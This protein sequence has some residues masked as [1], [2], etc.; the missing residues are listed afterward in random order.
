MMKRF[1][2]IVLLCAGIFSCRTRQQEVKPEL[3]QLTEAIYASGT[4]VPEQEYRVMAASDG[5]LQQSLVREGDTVKKGQLLFTLSND[6]QQ[7]QVKAAT[8]VVARTMPVTAEN[9]PAVLEL[10]NRLQSANIRLQNDSV[11]YARYKNLFDQNAISASN[12][13]KFRLQYETTQ[14]DVL[15]LKQQLEQQRLSSALQLQ[16]AHNEL[17]MARTGKGNG[18]VKSFVDGVVFDVYH[19]PGDMVNPTMPIALV[20][21]GRMIARL[22]VD[23]DALSR[24]HNG[25]EVLVTMDAYPNKIFHAQIIKI[26]PLLNRVEQS[27]R[28]DAVFQDELPIKLYGLNVEANIVLSEKEKAMVIPRAALLQ[29][30]SVKIRDNGKI[31]M[32]KIIKGVQDADWVQVKGGPITATTTIIVQ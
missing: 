10:K 32:V 7:A 29:G 2:W 1:A 4:L 11:Q 16:Q 31:A 14:K 25:Q 17:N 22:S 24:V 28:V 26:Y 8:K 18:Q 15:G 13:E 23:E 12:Y 3:R 6:N 27:F 30:D 9:S 19:Q 21:S 20:G 5:F